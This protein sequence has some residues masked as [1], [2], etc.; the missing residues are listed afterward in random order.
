M[1]RTELR[2]LFD[3]DLCSIARTVELIGDRWSMLVLREAFYGVSRFEQLRENL[4]ISRAVLTDRLDGLIAA[5]LLER[6]PYQ[7]PGQRARNEYR[8][9]EAGTEL[10]PAFAALLAWGDKHRNNG[11]PPVTLTHAG[12]GAPLRSQLVCDKGHAV[13]ADEVEPEPGPGLRLS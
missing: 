11:M 13:T 10:M 3:G 7:S 9:T 12:C 2:A 6:V 4:R 5:G 8:L 1:D